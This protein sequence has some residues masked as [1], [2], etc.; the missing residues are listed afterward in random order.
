MAALADST[1]SMINFKPNSAIPP[2]ITMIHLTSPSPIV[3][4]QNLINIMDAKVPQKIEKQR[5]MKGFQPKLRAILR[6]MSAWWP[7]YESTTHKLRP[8]TPT[9]YKVSI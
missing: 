8:W 7:R 5:F 2:G 6:H 1:L 4:T 3:E 9:K